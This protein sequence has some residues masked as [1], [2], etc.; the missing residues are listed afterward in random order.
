MAGA[1]ATGA[2]ARSV[3]G[4]TPR[5]QWRR[6][7][8]LAVDGC[9]GELDERR[10]VAVVVGREVQRGLGDA[11]EGGEL[12]GRQREVE[13][14]EVRAEL[15]EPARAD[16]R[17]GHARATVDPRDRHGGRTRARLAGDVLERVNDV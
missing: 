16:E 10:E 17:G 2:R 4:V 9:A 5:Q 6:A 3:S 13:R 8:R 1:R 11:V 7:V 15:V 14:G 12:F